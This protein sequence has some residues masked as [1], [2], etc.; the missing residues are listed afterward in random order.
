VQLSTYLVRVRTPLDTRQ[1]S[2][3][4]PLD[5]R[6]SLLRTPLD[7]RLRSLSTHLRCRESG[8]LG[9]ATTLLLLRFLQIQ[10]LDRLLN[11]SVRGNH[12]LYFQF[13]MVIH[14]NTNS[15]TYLSDISWEDTTFQGIGHQRQVNGVLGNLVHMH[16]P[17]E[18][19]RSDGTTSPATCWD[20]YALALDATYGTFKGGSVERLLGKLFGHPFLKFYPLAH[21]TLLDFAIAE[22]ILLTK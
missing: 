18:V 4:T 1:S 6:W 22:T 9:R 17:G 21:L 16:Y 8:R 19:I 7:T 10:S 3:R 2:L 20:D 5:T 12:F 13:I 11:Q 14:A 15:C